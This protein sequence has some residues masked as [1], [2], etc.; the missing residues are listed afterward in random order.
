[1]QP[2]KVI[3]PRVVLQEF[4]HL[5]EQLWGR[6][7]WARRH[8]AVS[9]GSLT[10]EM[11]AQYTEEQ[12]GE[13]VH[14]DSQFP[15]DNHRNRGLVGAGCSLVPSCVVGMRHGSSLGEPERITICGLR[16]WENS[17]F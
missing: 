2:L 9:S 4:P 13:P 1:M 6:H 14:D 17:I 11:V 7:S 8:L 10:D 15:I 16:R 12:D 5:R 3:S